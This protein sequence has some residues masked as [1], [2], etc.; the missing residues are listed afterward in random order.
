MLFISL[1]LLARQEM[2]II[3]LVVSFAKL[4]HLVGSR[5]AMRDFGMPAALVDPTGT[6]LPVAELVVVTLIL[7]S[8]A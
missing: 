2:I 5:Q 8:S 3:F 4:T 6:L 1:H 7:P